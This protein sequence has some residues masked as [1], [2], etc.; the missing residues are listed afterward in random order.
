[1]TLLIAV[2]LIGEFNL[3]PVAYLGAF[4]VWLFHL[5]FHGMCVDE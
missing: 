5:G 2:I 3:P 4:I 1:M